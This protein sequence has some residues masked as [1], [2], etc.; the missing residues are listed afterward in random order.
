MPAQLSVISYADTPLAES[1]VP[2]LTAITMPLE[3]LGRAG[4]DMLLDELEGVEPHDV[5]I[6]DDL[7][8]VERASTAGPRTVP[9]SL[10]RAKVIA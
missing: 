2:P 8:I 1:L 7:R 6:R 5:T 10:D 4:V 9:I 3:Q